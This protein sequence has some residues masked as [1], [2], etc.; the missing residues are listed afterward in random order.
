M[1]C[2]M[3]LPCIQV[4]D[5]FWQFLLFVCIVRWYFKGFFTRHTKRKPICSM[6]LYLWPLWAACGRRNSAMFYLDNRMVEATRFLKCSGK[7]E[8][9]AKKQN[10][11]SQV[12]LIKGYETNLR[13]LEYFG[14]IFFY[15]NTVTYLLWRSSLI[16]VHQGKRWTNVQLLVTCARRWFERTWP[17]GKPGYLPAKTG[18]NAGGEDDQSK[19]GQKELFGPGACWI[20]WK[21]LRFRGR[22]ASV[23]RYMMIHHDKMSILIH[24]I[25]SPS[26]NYVCIYILH[27]WYIVDHPHVHMLF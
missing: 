20:S 8:I 11:I 10:S 17:M 19:D 12:V 24:L 7:V 14:P 22:E 1:L 13:Y 15:G 4:F 16:F 27:Y 23:S 26:K 25:R 21:K 18:G 6:W 9:S 5:M 3:S 2:M